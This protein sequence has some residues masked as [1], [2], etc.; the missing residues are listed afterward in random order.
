MQKSEAYEERREEM[1]ISIWDNRNSKI[2]LV[3][4]CKYII[5]MDRTTGFSQRYQFSFRPPPQ[6]QSLFSVSVGTLTSYFA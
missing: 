1:L 2:F 6:C 4:E 3:L 5:A